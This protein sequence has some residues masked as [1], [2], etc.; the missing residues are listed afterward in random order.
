MS[1]AFCYNAHVVVGSC[2]QGSRMRS[3]SYTEWDWFWI[4]WPIRSLE[5]LIHFAWLPHLNGWSYANQ[6]SKT[7]LWVRLLSNCQNTQNLS[8][9]FNVKNVV[10]SFEHE[11]SIKPVV[12]FIRCQCKV[13]RLQYTFRSIIFFKSGFLGQN[14]GWSVIFDFLRQKLLRLNSGGEIVVSCWRRK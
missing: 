11:S 3:F 1:A 14:I 7:Q 9:N 10:A 2:G 4:N 5:I 12:W 6:R 8:V 13:V